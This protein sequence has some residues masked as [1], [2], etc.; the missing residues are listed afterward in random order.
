LLAPID[1]DPEDDDDDK[2]PAKKEDEVKI[3]E[4]VTKETA[5]EVKGLSAEEA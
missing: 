5:E 2:Y 1:S 3:E 4:A